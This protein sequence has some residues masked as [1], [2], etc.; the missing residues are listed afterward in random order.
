MNAQRRLLSSNGWM[1]LGRAIASRL[2]QD[3]VFLTEQRPHLPIMCHRL[4]LGKRERYLTLVL[5]RVLWD[6]RRRT[7]DNEGVYQGTGYPP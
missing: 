2:Q 5:L 7:A 1:S 3:R 4:A 6:G